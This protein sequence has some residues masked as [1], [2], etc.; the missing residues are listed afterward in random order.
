[1]SPPRRQRFC[2]ALDRASSTPKDVDF[3]DCYFSPDRPARLDFA[4][5]P[6][7]GS[8]PSTARPAHVSGPAYFPP[9][10]HGR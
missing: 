5:L 10:S 7:E 1:M 8:S 4:D 9:E 6:V 3:S 2:A